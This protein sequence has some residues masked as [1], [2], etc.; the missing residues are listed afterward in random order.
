MITYYEDDVDRVAEVIKREFALDSE[1]SVDRE[2]HRARSV[3]LQ[4][5]NY[6][7]T[8]LPKRTA[9]VEYKRFAGVRCEIQITSILMHAWSE[10]EH[11]WYDLK[12][13]YPDKVKRRFYRIAALL[14][15]AESEFLNLKKIRI[16]LPAIGCGPS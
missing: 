6:V 15:L 11:E 13:A 3:R 14:E 9:D 4:R 5:L 16:G 10:I 8:H 1:N 7:C 2:R 12:D